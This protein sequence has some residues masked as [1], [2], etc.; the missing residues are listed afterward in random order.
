MD[1]ILKAVLERVRPTE[2]ERRRLQRIAAKLIRRVD[3][4]CAKLGVSARAMLVGSAARGTW[5]RTERDIDIFILFP[6]ELP[7]EELEKKGLAV[8]REVAG[9]K[10]KEQFAEHPYVTTKLDGFEVDLVP[11]YDI[12]EPSRIKSAVD[13]TPHH[14]RYISKRLTPKLRD[15]VLLLKQFL[16]GIGVYGAELKI[17][18]FSGYLCELLT[19]NYRS[20]KNVVAAASAWSPGTVIDLE[21]S[22]PDINEA[23]A[24]FAG[25]PLIVIDPVDANRNAGAAVSMQNFATFV[26]ACQD[27][28]REPSM[29]F[30]FPKPVR[31]L[32]SREVRAIMKRRGT[33]LFCIAFK[34]PDVVPD[35]LYP[36]LRKTERTLSTNLARAGFEVLRSDVWSN[37]NSILL[38]ELTVARLPNVRIHAGPPITVGVG[39]FVEKH[40]HSKRKFTGPFVDDAGKLVFEIE[41]EQ[42]DARQVIEQALTKRAAFGRHVAE[43]LAVKYEIYEGGQI[44]EFCR[45]KKIRKFISE[46]LTRCLPWYR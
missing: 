37:D 24:L 17:Q 4:A 29:R 40:L 13:R 43:A 32:S 28:L 30:F 16:S 39:G 25:Q 15:E 27:F 33:A 35:V 21:R 23:R 1:E 45:D 26:R 38:L 42:T 46:Y 19:L 44:A 14:N 2:A 5:L 11:C 18:G 3:D 12:P 36:Q 34:S 7:R 20:F 6:K 8:A 31:L 41:R 9:R 10:R 22:Y